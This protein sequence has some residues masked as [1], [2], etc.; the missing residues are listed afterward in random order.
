MA[1]NKKPCIYCDVLTTKGKRGEHIIQEAIGGALTLLD[2]PEQRFVCTACN[3]GVL[4]E[5]DK[6][7]TSKSYLSIVASQEL[8][9]CRTE[10]GL[11][12]ELADKC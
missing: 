2:I 4:G 10:Y 7:F 3:N 5:I 12:Q 1:A 11:S 9:A 6:E 8:H